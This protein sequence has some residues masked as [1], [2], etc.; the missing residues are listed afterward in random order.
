M[1]HLV[2]LAIAT[3]LK[4]SSGLDNGLALTPPMGWLSWERFRCNTDCKD[5]PD[6]CIGEKL[7]MDMAD[8]LVADGYK[9]VG[10]EYVHIDDCWM[11][12]ERD[13]KTGRLV[14]DPARFPRG[15][16]ALAD[17]IHSKGL[18]LAIYEDFGS[19]TCAGYPGSEFYLMT[20]A[21]TF[22]EWGIDMLKFDTCNNNHDDLNYGFPAMEIFLNNTGRP[23]LFSCEWPHALPTP[24]YAAVRKSCNMWRVYRD[25]EDSW[26]TVT[27]IINFY[28]Q[29]KEWFSNYT[30]PGGWADPDM[31]V[32]GDFGLSDS[33]QKA[34]MAMWAMFSAPLL[35]S[36]EL[37][38]IDP[39]A[40]A[41]LQ[42]KNVIAINQDPLGNQAIKIYQFP[43][44]QVSVWLK[45]LFAE[46][47]FALAF[48][49]I[50][51]GG[52]FT[53]CQTTLFFLG[54]RNTNGYNVTEI[55]ENVPFG[56]YKPT[57]KF[58]V[59]V[60]PSSIVFLKAVPL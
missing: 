19:K 51:G 58:L 3:F 52:G 18:K 10:Y 32:V 4:L 50:N 41:L 15:M 55:F 6:I 33:Q 12:E 5:Y 1:M 48:L 49:N 46:G 47:S 17:Y 36:V 37:R 13:N 24:D 26:D 16:K 54:L 42:N 39:R 35:M 8:R 22:A 45:R 31:L 25:V 14:A 27:D 23:I 20:D 44:T 38:N 57:D 21:N 53:P 60:F 40:K 2:V 29:N 7:Y 9:E 30:G 28:A 56:I 43:G 34:Q 59:N 11:A